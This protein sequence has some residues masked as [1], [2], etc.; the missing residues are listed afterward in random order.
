M[1]LL[2]LASIKWLSLTCGFCL[3]VKFLPF[4][5]FHDFCFFL[6]LVKF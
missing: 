6:L 4:L 1:V 3:M 2:I 5:G